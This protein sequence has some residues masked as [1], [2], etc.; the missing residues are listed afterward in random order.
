MRFRTCL[1]YLCFVME[2]KQ[3]HN[4]VPA[5]LEI[6]KKQGQEILKLQ[7]QLEQL[8]R[9][10]YGRKS[11]RF[12]VNPSQAALPFDIPSSV[13]PEKQKE[14]ITYTREKKSATSK[15]KGRMPLPCLLYTSPSPRDRTRSRMPSSA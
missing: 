3:N 10:T 6:I 1:T 15:H 4:E 11:E 2:T 5:L 8:L 14:T 7:Q 13:E 9:N 12:V